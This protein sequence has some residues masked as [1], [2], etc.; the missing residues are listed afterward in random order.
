MVFGIRVSYHDSQVAGSESYR[1]RPP[2]CPCAA[3]FDREEHEASR[4]A[5]QSPA[6]ELRI[7]HNP[8][9]RLIMGGGGGAG[10]HNNNNNNNRFG[11]SLGRR[12][13]GLSVTSVDSARPLRTA[14]QGVPWVGGDVGGSKRG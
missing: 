4:A 14:A 12:L 7:P 9:A 5:C 13:S 2:V 10:G 1:Q 3:C 6:R 8:F 11:V